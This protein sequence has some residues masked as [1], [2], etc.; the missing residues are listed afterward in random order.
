MKARLSVLAITAV[1]MVPGCTPSDQADSAIPPLPREIIDL[2]TLVTEDLPERVWGRAF[3]AQMGF[4]ENNTFDVRYWNVEFPD[5]MVSGSNS[6]FTLFNHGG[7]H[8]DAPNH[9][10]LG[11]GLDSYAIESFTGPLKVVDV[12][13]FPLGRSVPVDE[14]RSHDIRPGDIVLI[15][16][17][18]TPPI[19]GDVP[20][21]IAL[22]REAAEYLAEL[23]V[24]AFGTDAFNVDSDDNP[25]PV[26]S[27]SATERVGPNHYT[28]LTR[29]IPIFEQLFNVDRL[30]D[31]E[32]MYFVGPPLNIK[33]ADGMMVRPVALVY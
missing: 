16:T 26:Q 10:N 32:N 7:P 19:E 11:T 5:G 22:T 31:E 3:M 24:R 27:D 18:Y 17:G 15:Y 33:D 1:I 14:I 25:K 13:E 8:V 29:G 9:M 21:R 2:G 23:P 20:H 6:Y 4:S 12:S 30:V 28:F